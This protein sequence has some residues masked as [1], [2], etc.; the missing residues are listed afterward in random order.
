MLL[1]LFAILIILRKQLC[2]MMIDAHL[3]AEMKNRLIK[4]RKAFRQAAKIPFRIR[5]ENRLF[6]VQLVG[7]ATR[8]IRQGSHLNFACKP[9]GLQKTLSIFKW[10]HFIIQNDLFAINYICD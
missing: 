1:R 6:S 9:F 10:R 5:I 8:T 4:W 2:T 3:S 7:R